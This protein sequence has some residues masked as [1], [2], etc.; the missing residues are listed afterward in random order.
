MAKMSQKSIFLIRAVC[1]ELLADGGRLF[2][3]NIASPN[4][5]RVW[6]EYLADWHLIERSAE[7]LRW[8]AAAT[9]GSEVTCGL[10]REGS[11]MTWLMTIEPE[12]VVAG[13]VVVKPLT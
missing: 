4:P 1:N 3:T 10:R 11:G 7:E 2:L 12:H 9:A 8:L 5:Y 13:I 6:I